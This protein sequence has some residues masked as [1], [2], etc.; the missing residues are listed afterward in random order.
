MFFCGLH[1]CTH[2][3]ACIHHTHT[4]FHTYTH[5]LTLSSPQVHLWLWYNI[6]QTIRLSFTSE[7]DLI[8]A[9][10]PE[11]LLKEKVPSLR[12][13][14]S[15]YLQQYKNQTRKPRHDFLELSIIS[16]W[17]FSWKESK[18]FKDSCDHL[19]HFWASWGAPCCGGGS[20]RQELSVWYTHSRLCLSRLE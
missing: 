17:L 20:H 5:N 4:T 16:G 10:Q 13:T 19:R 12:V 9:A 7:C 15:L 3:C 6:T 14:S 11:S 2:P 1:M 8:F 18:V